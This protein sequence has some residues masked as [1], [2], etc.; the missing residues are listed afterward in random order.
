MSIPRLSFFLFSTVEQ[1]LDNLS[2]RQIE[3][4]LRETDDVARKKRLYKFDKRDIVLR[5]PIEVWMRD[6]AV[7]SHFRAELLRVAS[8]VVN[9]NARKRSLHTM[10]CSYCPLFCDHDGAAFEVLAVSDR[11]HEVFLGRC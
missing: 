6:N 9:V 11:Q 10:S 7:D 2:I 4:R 1:T 3:L 5:S 8:A